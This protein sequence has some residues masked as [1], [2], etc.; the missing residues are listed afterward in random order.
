VDVLYIYVGGERILRDGI[1]LYN[2]V[3]DWILGRYG[4]GRLGLFMEWVGVEGGGIEEWEGMVLGDERVCILR[5]VLRVRYRG[6][7]CVE[8]WVCNKLARSGIDLR[9][10]DEGD[11][12]GVRVVDSVVWVY[13]GSTNDRGIYGRLCRELQYNRVVGEVVRGGGLVHPLS[14]GMRELEGMIKDGLVYGV[15][16][17]LSDGD[18]LFSPEVEVSL[19]DELSSKYYRYVNGMGD[20]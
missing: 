16:P 19:K 11:N 18:V 1:G 20:N 17:E 4:R 5:E 2:R 8:F 15:I 14:V 9:G 10:G 7:S 3:C 6:S 13:V 12:L